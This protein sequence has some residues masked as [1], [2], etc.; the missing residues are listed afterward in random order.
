M[1]LFIDSPSGGRPPRLKR[2]IGLWTATALVVGN[3]VGS[4]V[5]LLPS[6]LAATGGPVSMLV[7]LFTG[8]GAILLA[9]VFANLGRAFP[10]TGGPYAYAR[11]ALGDFIGFQTAWCYWIAVWAGSAAIAGAELGR[12]RGG[13]RCM[14]CPIDRDDLPES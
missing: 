8:A 9:L 7:W 4:G 1:P 3:M 10:R 6:S 5:F 13:P 14:S 11:R 2:T 12:G